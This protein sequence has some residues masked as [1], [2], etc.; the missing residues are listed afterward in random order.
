MSDEGVRV[1]IG[2]LLEDLANN[3]EIS[4]G[5]KLAMFVSIV[6]VQVIL[7]QLTANA[8]MHKLGMTPPSPVDAFAAA[9]LRLGRPELFPDD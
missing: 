5:D 6:D 7:K 9:I 1:A 8:L 3:D 2:P 4:R